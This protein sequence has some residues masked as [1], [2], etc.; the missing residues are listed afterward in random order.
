MGKT[1]AIKLH[2]ADAT[3][4]N[5]DTTTGKGQT[6]VIKVARHVNV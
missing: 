4:L 5:V 1:Y 3:V 2:A 6:A